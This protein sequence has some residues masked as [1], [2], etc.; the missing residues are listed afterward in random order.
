MPPGHNVD[1]AN[2]RPL[3]VGFGSQGHSAGTI[4]DVRIYGG[5][6]AESE[7]REIRAEAEKRE[8]STV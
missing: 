1:L 8:R 3:T 7:V 6:L 2:T 5:A 4:G